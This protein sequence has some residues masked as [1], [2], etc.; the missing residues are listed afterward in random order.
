MRSCFLKHLRA[1]QF[2]WDRECSSAGTMTRQCCFAWAQLWFL[3]FSDHAEV[4]MLHLVLLEATLELPSWALPC[5]GSLIMV[6]VKETMQV[7]EGSRGEQ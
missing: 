1:G 3:V 4:P 6:Q 7:R 5:V 2:V